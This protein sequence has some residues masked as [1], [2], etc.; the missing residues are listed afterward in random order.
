MNKNM[1]LLYTLIML[2]CRLSLEDA[3]RIFGV[4]RRELWENLT[5]NV[6]GQDYYHSIKHL[7]YEVSCYKGNN[8]KGVFKAQL[9][10]RRLRKILKIQDKAERKEKLQNLY[11]D[12][13]GPDIRFAFDKITIYSP[14]ERELILKYCL[15]YGRTG[16]Q[17]EKDFHITHEAI[18]KW[19][20]ELPNGELKERLKILREYR[21]DLYFARNRKRGHKHE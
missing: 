21:Q 16:V 7:L 8:E 5:I 9:Y 2:E 10:I 1:V 4:E 18:K 14:K 13:M 17:M 3:S 15:K 6:I 12:L 20:E 11:Q 19:E